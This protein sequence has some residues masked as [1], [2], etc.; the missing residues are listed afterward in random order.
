MI[1][2]KRTFLFFSI[3][4]SICFFACKD[5][6]K[7][8]TPSTTDT[9]II[10]NGKQILTPTDHKNIYAD[11]DVSPMDMSYF[12]PNYPQL[13][14]AN[15]NLEQ[16]VLRIIYSRP[17]LQGRTLFHDILKYDE[18]WRLGANEATE[19]QVYQ[20]VTINGNKLS[21]GRYTLH[22]IPQQNEWTIVF[23]SAVDIWGLKFD[24]AKDILKV[25]IPVFHENPSIEYFTM[26]FEKSD[27]GA[28]LVMAWGD[29]LAKLP[30]SF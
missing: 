16:P 28:N 25:K 1:P 6:E 26:F 4:S 24:P 11:V 14:M 13:K 15:P 8:Q 23:N 2:L 19:L 17:H 5:G 7:K 12:P 20:T 30:F 3:L 21:K 29:V 22:C 18:P 27:S 10:I 9:P